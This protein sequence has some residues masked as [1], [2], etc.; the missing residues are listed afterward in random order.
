MP[1]C[2]CGYTARPDSSADAPGQSP[3]HRGAAGHGITA[4]H[5]HLKVA[6]VEVSPLSAEGTDVTGDAAHIDCD[7]V[8]MSGGLS[9]VVHL[10]SQARGKL[11]WDENFMFPPSTT[12]EAEQSVGSCNGSFDL[13]KGL[14]EAG[15][16]P[17][18]PQG[19]W[20]AN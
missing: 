15:P 18:G 6:R 2:H 4:A 11:I 5:G 19:R 10:H 16:P 12:H 13:Q 1:D 9:P 14:R 20:P 7:C 8:L 17:A 3:E